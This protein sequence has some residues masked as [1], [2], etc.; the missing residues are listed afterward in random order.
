MTAP[1]RSADPRGPA[2]DR[3]PAPHRRRDELGRG[4][5]AR[6]G[7]DRA[8]AVA[9]AARAQHGVPR[10]GRD[11]P[12]ARRPSG[13]TVEAQTPFPP[14]EEYA[15]LSDCH[16]GALV[17]A[18]RLG[19]VAVRAELRL[20]EHLRQP[21]RPRGRLVPVRTVRHRAPDRPR[22]RPGHERDGDDLPHAVRLARRPGRADHRAATAG[23]R[24]HA[25]PPA[26]DRRGRR[27]HAGAH[28][29]VHRG[30]RRDRADLHPGLRLRP[31]AGDLDAASATTGTWPRQPGPSRASRSR[32]CGCGPTWR[33]A[34]RATGSGPAGSCRLGRPGLLRAV[35][36]RA[37]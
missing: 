27:P 5:P 37:V 22:L 1:R 32:R 36:G 24:D 23:R 7:P 15:F 10:P 19:R 21:A 34:S 4:Q 16:T 13:R 12:A 14:I 11:R 35:L 26:A 33:S 17:A 29:R 20:A 2:P 25:A 8:D 31:D 18:G 6:P 28:G 9:V 30:P 3:V